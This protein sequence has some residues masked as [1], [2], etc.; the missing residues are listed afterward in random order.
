MG[1]TV[2][3]RGMSIRTLLF[4]DVVESTRLVERV[5]DARAAELWS[6]HDRRSRA[7]LAQHRGREIDR[8]DGFFLLFEEPLDAARYALGYHQTV[9]DLD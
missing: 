3:L 7:L 1:H 8:T 5:G 2:G 6:T 9:A 4:T